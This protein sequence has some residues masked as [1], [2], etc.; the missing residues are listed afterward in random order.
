[1]SKLPRK[2]SPRSGTP[3]AP[4]VGRQSPL[5]EP[6]APR[7]HGPR[8]GPAGTLPPR[9]FQRLAR[10]ARCPRTVMACGGAAGRLQRNFQPGGG[11]PGAPLPPSQPLG[12]PRPHPRNPARPGARAPPPCPRRTLAQPGR[13]GR[14]AGRSPSGEAGGG[15]GRRAEA[16][17]Q[18]GRQGWVVLGPGRTPALGGPRRPTLTLP[19]TSPNSPLSSRRA[20]RAPAP[21]AEEARPQ[22]LGAATAAA[23][24]PF[25]SPLLLPGSGAAEWPGKVWFRPLCRFPPGIGLFASLAPGPSAM[26]GCFIDKSGSDGSSHGLGALLRR[27]G[28]I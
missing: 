21:A 4:G 25:P 16:G 1:M 24:V 26:I 3:Q 5:E 20:C 23:S 13:G 28:S 17:A 14:Q 10:P 15:G 6:P 8:A 11:W 19:S 12:H 27:A 7:P 9:G 2:V 22:A 18:G